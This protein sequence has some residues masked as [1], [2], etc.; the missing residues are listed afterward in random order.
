MSSVK[1]ILKTLYSEKVVPE[2][3]KSQGYKNLHDVPRIVKVVI[4]SGV[5]TKHDKSFLENAVRDI[6]LITCQKPIVTKARLSVSNFKLRE[7]MPVGVKVTLRGENMWNFIYRFVNLALPAIRDFRGLSNKLDGNGNYNMGIDDHTIFPE[8]SGDSKH[9]NLGMDITVVTT[10]KTD[11]EGREL[12]KL[13][14]VP[15]RKN[16]SEEQAA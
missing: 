5:G 13:V 7:G 4:N 10:A 1:P 11:E 12:L 9:I 3:I 15:F 6:G 14:G 16:S 2:L 8:I